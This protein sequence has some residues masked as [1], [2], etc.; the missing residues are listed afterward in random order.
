VQAGLAGNTHGQSSG[1]RTSEPSLLA[2]KLF[3]ETGA[4]L[5]PSHAVKLGRRYRYYISAHLIDRSANSSP[6]RQRD[7]WRLPAREIERIVSNAVTSLLADPAR[8]A[9]A[10]RDAG[11]AAEGISGLLN[12]A[13]RWQNR[14]MDLV[15]RVDLGT[16]AVA[17]HVSLAPLIRDYCITIL[18]TVPVRLRRR[19]VEMRLVLPGQ[20]NGGR[21]AKPD[22]ALIKAVLR[23]HKWFDDLV[24]G[25]AASLKAIAQ[26][27]GYSDRYVSQL[28]PLAF[29]APVIV[30]AILAGTQPVDLTAETLTKRTDLSLDWAEQ[31]ALLGFD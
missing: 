31:M 25:R 9:S 13:A 3:D 4:R 5:T 14:P 17:I 22:A 24:S 29:L 1:K 28:A 27:E 18:H 10:A 6:D 7:G 21:T 16:D 26:A 30:E 15:E 8:L 11:M 12:A 19:G 23:A 2:G 20:G